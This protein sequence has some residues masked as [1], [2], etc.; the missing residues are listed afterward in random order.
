MNKIPAPHKKHPRNPASFDK[1]VFLKKKQQTS[2]KKNYAHT[3]ISIK[4][5]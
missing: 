2:Q 5:N 3:G 1:L 4:S